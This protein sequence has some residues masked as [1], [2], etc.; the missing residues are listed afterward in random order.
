MEIEL[1]PNQREVTSQ[2]SQRKNSAQTNFTWR[3]SNGWANSEGIAA[4]HFAVDGYH[5]Q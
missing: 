2:L 1:A 3:Q 5:I 4:I